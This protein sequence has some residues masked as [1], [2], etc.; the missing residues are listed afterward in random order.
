MS[1]QFL[2]A[3]SNTGDLETRT[4]RGCRYSC[5]CWSL[6]SFQKRVLPASVI[7]SHPTVL[8]LDLGMFFRL[9]PIRIRLFGW[10]NGMGR[11]AGFVFMLTEITSFA[12]CGSL[13]TYALHAI[14]GQASPLWPYAYEVSRNLK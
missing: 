3:I 5:G 2:V 7:Y 11:L 1:P 6:L 14:C 9:F 13:I 4:E 10:T 8:V 12:P